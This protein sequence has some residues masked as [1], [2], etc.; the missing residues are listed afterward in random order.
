MIL[1]T[2][3]CGYIGSHIVKALSESGEKVIVYD[4][5]SYGSAD[6]L[7]HKEPL[8]IGDITNLL[9]LEQVFSEHR[10]EC[11][12]HC[13]ALVNAAES[14][15]KANEYRQVNEKGSANVWSAAQKAGVKYMLYASSAAVYGTPASQAPLLESTL[16]HP[17]NVY[18]HSPGLLI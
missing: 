2:G 12:I 15:S 8:I 13:A 5:L 9:S 11:V 16:T 14:N 17:I 4:N 1:V 10:I 18:P 3:G 7:L 6:S